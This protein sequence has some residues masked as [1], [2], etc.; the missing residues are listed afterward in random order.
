VS[1]KI[2]Q[3]W[4][5]AAAAAQSV[6]CEKLSFQEEKKV[7]YGKEGE[8]LIS[9]TEGFI[10]I[11]IGFSRPCVHIPTLTRRAIAQGKLE[12]AE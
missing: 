2:W 4:A 10:L 1:R 12:P 3:P 5:A 6:I 8:T 7:I 11:F 9:F